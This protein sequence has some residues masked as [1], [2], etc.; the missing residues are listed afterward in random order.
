MKKV[1]W[2]ILAAAMLL[3]LT[4]CEFGDSYDDGYS[5]GYDDGYEDGYED[6]YRDALAEMQAEQSLTDSLPTDSVGALTPLPEPESGTILSG[7]ESD[8]SELSVSADSTSSYVVKL[9][10]ESGEERLSFYVRA[11]DT[12]TIGVPAEYL[13]VYFASGYEWYGEEL[14]FGESTAYS[15]DDEVLDFTQ[16]TWEYTLYPV[17]D[18]NFEETPIDASEFN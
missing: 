9:K 7:S 18:G 1:L 15:K 3:C 16:Y 11:G 6:G 5:D 4:A 2:L 8:A 10:T 14:L 13:Y 12:V 17:T